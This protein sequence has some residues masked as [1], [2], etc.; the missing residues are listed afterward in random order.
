MALCCLYVALA[1][2]SSSHY[3]QNADKSAYAIIKQKQQEALGRTEPF[4]VESPAN[5][6]RRQLLINQELQHGGPAS[7]G[8]SDLQPV[9]HWPEEDKKPPR[10]PIV[11]DESTPIA[12]DLTVS[13]TRALQ[14]SAQNSPEYQ[15]KKEEVFRRA[16]DLDFARDQFRHTMAGQF[17]GE[18]TEDRNYTDSAGGVQ[19]GIE[20]S[21]LAK[22]S[23]TFLNGITLTAQ[24]GL[25]LVQMLQPSRAFSSAIL[26]D[27]SVT[28]PLLRGA[29]RHIASEPLTQAERE[30]LYAIRDFEQFKKE[31][32]VTIADRYF[33][34][35]Q[36]EDQLH[37]QEENYRG[38]IVS[39]RRAS[40]LA[41]AGKT[42]IIQVDQSLQNELRARD[43]WIAARQSYFRA[44]D[45][46][47]IILGL[48]TDAEIQLDRQDFNNLESLIYKRLAS[49]F[50]PKAQRF[51]RLKPLLL[52]FYQLTRS[53]ASLNWKYLKPSASHWPIV[54]I[55]SIR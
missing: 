50:T 17:S 30:V 43:R 40:R 19:E 22:L 32:S 37:N 7:L 39:S 31:F 41:E 15:T 3:R 26:G 1:S 55:C 16:L 51:H 21:S 27:T 6:L 48:P 8:S 49:L 11:A 5:L 28:I 36:T 2:C 10:P 13:L 14:I 9:D 34:V 45:Q 20:S 29:G 54:W 52:L 42:P 12:T 47:K 24:L 4:S 46:F 23:R 53:A 44:L 18:F 25:D 35:L 33:T 38:L